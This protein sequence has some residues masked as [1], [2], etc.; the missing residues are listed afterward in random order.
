MA[1]TEL[2]KPLLRILFLA[3]DPSNTSK[4]RLGEELQEI[5]NR[6]ESNL[7]F[8][9]KDR[10]AVKPDDVLRTIL[11]YKPHIVHFSGHGED[12]GEICFEDEEGKSKTIPPD[13]LAQIFKL[14]NEYVKCVLVNTCYS[15]SQAKAIAQYV[16]IVIGTRKEITDSAAIKFSTGFYTA[17][18]PDLTQKTLKNAYESGCIAVRFENLEEHLTPVIIE[19]SPEVKFSSEV[20]TALLPITKPEGIVFDTLIKGLTLT[21]IKMGVTGDI[22]TKILEEKISKLTLYN[23]A[24]VEYEK[25]LKKILY[26][27]FPLSETSRSALFQLQYGL[28]LSNEDVSTITDKVLSDPKLTSAEAW[29]DR[30]RV[31]YGQK[32]MLKSIEYYN[33][34]IEK[35]PDYS[36]AYYDRG[37][38]HYEMGNYDEAI[39]DFGKALEY[40]NKWEWL[41]ASSAYFSR[42]LAYYYHKTDDKDLKAKYMELAIKDWKE[43]NKLKYSE[44]LGYYNIGCAH[45]HLNNIEEAIENY[46]KSFELSDSNQKK[47]ECATKL[48]KSYNNLENQG[49]ADKWRNIALDFWDQRD[50]DKG[51]ELGV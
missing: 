45:E 20:D 50:E 41:S 3:S 17:L 35:C 46:K 43:S 23:E 47:Y 37:I 33:D 10:Q 34:S 22:V 1:N 6:L 48:A 8:E 39:A 26:D 30:G 24:L 16:P 9:I 21:G 44:Q 5:R 12:T 14:V 32:N 19:G 13:A 42:G 11:N 31:Q 2:E 36:A 28:D 25:H 49:E 27:E 38:S 51:D 15:E 18:D 7:H 40:N 29:Y 4:I